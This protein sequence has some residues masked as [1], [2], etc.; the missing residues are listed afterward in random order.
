MLEKLFQYN[1]QVRN[2]WFEWC[3][4][5]PYEELIQKRIGGMR[6]FLHTLY[7]V[8]DCEQLWINQ[9]WSKPVMTTDLKAITQLN[10][11][12]SFDAATRSRTKLFLHEL[13]NSWGG[14][15]VLEIQ[16]RNGEMLRLPYEKVLYHIVTHEVH[17]IGQ[18]SIWA[19]EMG[20]APVNSDL[21]IRDF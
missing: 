14:N 11:V 4:E 3:E 15:R 9:M 12:K 20:R 10:E 18:L 7:H 6:S 5:I 13:A 2:E 16:K 17:H 21:L 1:W 8:I 19:R